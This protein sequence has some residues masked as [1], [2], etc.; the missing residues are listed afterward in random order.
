M[1]G[2]LFS[3]YIQLGTEDIAALKKL[4]DDRNMNYSS[5]A[6]T[7]GI[8]NGE[9]PSILAT[10]DEIKIMLERANNVHTGKAREYWA[11]KI[12]SKILRGKDV[13]QIWN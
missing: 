1:I 11:K 8:W 10:A 6:K 5:L 4:K 12:E 13:V 7:R 9:R 3:Q 2:R